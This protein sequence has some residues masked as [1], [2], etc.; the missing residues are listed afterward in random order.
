VFNK[1]NGINETVEKMSA[2]RK[3]VR[4][5]GFLNRNWL[6][7]VGWVGARGKNRLKKG[8]RNRKNIDRRQYLRMNLQKGREDFTH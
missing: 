8:T 4:R 6:S 7:T 1:G 5:T 2:M 3:K